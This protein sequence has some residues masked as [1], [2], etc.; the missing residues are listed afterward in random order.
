VAAARPAGSDPTPRGG[1][2]AAR[3]HG[4]GGRARKR[5]E[6]YSS[7]CE[8]FSLAQFT[9]IGTRPLGVGLP[10]VRGTTIHLYQLGGSLVPY[11]EGETAEPDATFAGTLEMTDEELRG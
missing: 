5:R 11:L 7:T 2:C 8:S 6:H 9:L 10:W 1:D 4:A 3:R